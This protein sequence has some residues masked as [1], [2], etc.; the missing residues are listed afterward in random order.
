MSKLRHNK[1]LVLFFL[2]FKSQHLAS[3][4]KNPQPTNMTAIIR[5]VSKLPCNTANLYAIVLKEITEN[6]SSRVMHLHDPEN[7]SGENS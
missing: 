4:S 7:I 3:L 2:K 1:N 6:I 5:R